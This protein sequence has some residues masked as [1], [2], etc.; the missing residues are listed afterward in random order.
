MEVDMMPQW[1][2]RENSKWKWWASRMVDGML[3]EFMHE[4]ASFRWTPPPFSQVLVNQKQVTGKW[5]SVQT[6]TGSDKAKKKTNKQTNKLTDQDCYWRFQ[7]LKQAVSS[8][9][10]R[11]KPINRKFREDSSN[12]ATSKN[13]G[14]E[15]LVL[16]FLFTPFLLGMGL[17]AGA[18]RG[19]SIMLKSMLFGICF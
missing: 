3:G 12:Q 1:W 5:Q 6:K 10:Q 9:S 15:K 18:P 14:E 8:A 11:G 13:N 2:Q 17:V 4:I 16:L 7:K 19:F